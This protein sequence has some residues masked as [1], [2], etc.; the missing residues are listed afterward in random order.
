[1]DSVTVATG[2]AYK[3]GAAEPAGESR[4]LGRVSS[5]RPI[6]VAAGPAPGDE[7]LRRAY[8]ELLKLSL[9][10]L[11]GVGTTSVQ[12][13]AHGQ[14]EARE[15][16]GAD[17]VERAEGRDWPRHAVT[18][19]GLRRLDA[20]QACVE[21]VVRD[22]IPGEL[23][24][25]G[26]WRGGSSILA[27]A[28]L[29]ALGDGRRIWVADSF[30]GFPSANP[31]EY[32]HS[33]GAF[34]AAFDYLAVP[35]EAVAANF[36]RFGLSTGVTFLP[37]LFKDTLPS[38][39]GRRWSLLRLDGDTY[40]ATLDALRALYPGLAP[41]GFV[42]VDDYRALAECREAVEVFRAE[43]GVEEPIEPIDWTGALWRR[44]PAAAPSGVAEPA[45]PSGSV[46]LEALSG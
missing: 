3:A 10:D 43:A 6:A 13:R 21:R 40:D 44:D 8:L 14:L 34:L 18:M 46:R 5:K 37:G 22:G 20:L 32:P 39:A 38:L 31:P 41:G 15:L 45:D 11:A 12:G 30:Q 19:T 42:I 26:T 17:L 2:P 36:R 28:T 4:T 33:A 24:E 7:A 25:T 35:V 27:R 1:V 23:I 29:D 9:C 16:S